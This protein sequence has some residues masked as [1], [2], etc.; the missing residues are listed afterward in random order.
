MR[1]HRRQP[2]RLPRPWDS[3][4]KNTGVGCQFLLQDCYF[5][6]DW[7]YLF[8]YHYT[9]GPCWLSI[10]TPNVF[11]INI[12]NSYI[13]YRLTINQD[14]PGGSVVKNSPTNAGDKSS[15]PGWGRSPAEEMATHSSILAW[16][17]PWTEEPK[18]LQSMGS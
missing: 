11:L 18:G 17:I 9:V 12:N 5:F 3:P 2:T 7:M 10:L 15:S 4:G 16:E 6:Y 13:Y 8:I 14:F 1:P